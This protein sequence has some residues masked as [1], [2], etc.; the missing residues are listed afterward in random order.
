M[1]RTNKSRAARA[2]VG[3]ASRST[4][5]RVSDPS[6]ETFAG[7]DAPSRIAGADGGGRHGKI[8]TSVCHSSLMIG[9]L[10]V[11]PIGLA[12]QAGRRCAVA[13]K[14]TGCP[15]RL[16]GSRRA[17]G[18]TPC[19]F[20]A[21]PSGKGD[22]FAANFPVFRYNYI[23]ISWLTESVATDWVRNPIRRGKSGAAIAPRH[24]RA[25]ALPPAARG[26]ARMDGARG[27]REACPGGAGGVLRRQQ[28]R[29]EGTR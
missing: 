20:P 24:G 22:K 1:W 19:Q 10:L 21:E 29:A 6:A 3:R 4:A 25:T 26:A 14:P 13:G 27:R 28:A 23:H 9:F 5:P 12:A 16:G 8:A 2:A 17:G 18:A 15:E 11:V 7:T